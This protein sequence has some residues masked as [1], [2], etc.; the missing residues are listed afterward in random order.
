MRASESA[1]FIN[2][3][4]LL[5]AKG[6]F[7]TDFAKDE[8]LDSELMK[9]IFDKNKNYIKIA[10]ELSKKFTQ[11][12]GPEFK[13]FVKLD[14]ETSSRAWTLHCGKE[15]V[16]IVEDDE[17]DEIPSRIRL[18]REKNIKKRKIETV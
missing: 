7:M 3:R 5:T 6:G 17:I 14:F 11:K 16:I 12:Y 9:E 4:G 15:N 1:N 8:H 2:L 13:G 10:D 18:L